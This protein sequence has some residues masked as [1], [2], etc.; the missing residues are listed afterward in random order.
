MIHNG[1]EGVNTLAP[2]MS[3]KYSIWLMPEGEARERLKGVISLL[4]E[5]YSTPLFEPHMT[6]IGGL[7]GKD[8]IRKA[9]G[10]ASLL[11]PLAISLREAGYEEDYYRC[12]YMR[13][14]ETDALLRA[15]EAAQEVFGRGD[16]QFMPHLSLMYGELPAYIKEEIIGQMGGKCAL[17]F[18]AESLRLFSTIGGPE[19]WRLIR[20]FPLKRGSTT[21]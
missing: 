17:S 16:G 2:L 1:P 9:S 14:E 19:D 21:S 18:R 12:L 8:N 10:L 11:S 20:E 4:G 3:N 7:P 13:A 15:N 6:L 5:R